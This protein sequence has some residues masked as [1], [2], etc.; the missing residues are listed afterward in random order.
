M[1]PVWLM[2]ALPI[3]ALV[4]ELTTATLMPPDTPTK[5]A[6][7]AT[8]SVSK[9]SDELACT[10]R[11]WRLAAL[12]PLAASPPLSVPLKVPPRPDAPP[13]LAS[14]E[15]LLATK[16]CVSLSMV[17]TPTEA[18]MP[19]TPAPSAPV[20]RKTL[21]SSSAITEVSPPDVTWPEIEASVWVLN[22]S[23]VTP[24]PTPTTPPPTPMPTSRMSSLA[25]ALTDT[26]SSALTVEPAP[27]A[28]PVLPFITV[29][30][31]PGATP[32]TP[33][34]KPAASAMW[35]KSLAAATLTVCAASAPAWL[36]L[37]SALLPM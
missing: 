18:P 27:M 25:K 29:T 34:P 1:P 5:P 4:S 11:P 17:S 28:A 19:T 26:S 6:P 31:T 21:V 32:T 12:K 20:S 14:T 24:P 7:A 30:S 9:L 22:T 16:A 3:Q 8:D 35:W 33:T 36:V 2:S 23:T 13:P 15:A 37:T 10:T